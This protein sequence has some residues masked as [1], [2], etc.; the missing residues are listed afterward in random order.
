MPPSIFILCIDSTDD[1]CNYFISGLKLRNHGISLKIFPRFTS[2]MVDYTAAS[3]SKSAFFWHGVKNAK[4]VEEYWELQKD[5]T[6]FPNC[7]AK[8]KK[9]HKITVNK[10]LVSWC[11]FVFLFLM[12]QGY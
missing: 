8:V 4:I 3:S 9:Y 2:F 12:Y 6:I 5:N 7:V 11:I 1:F 10:M